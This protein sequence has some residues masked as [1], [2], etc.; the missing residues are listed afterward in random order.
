MADK[1]PQFSK[2]LETRI[3][4]VILLTTLVVSLL[5][6]SITRHTFQG[7]LEDDVRA[8]THSVNEY[9]QRVI[10]VESFALLNERDDAQLPEYGQ[11]QRVLNDI[12]DIANI[13]YLFSAKRNSQGTIVYVVD[14]L[15]L[16]S[17]DFRFI[18]DPVEEEILP[19]M[20]TCLGGRIVGSDDILRTSWG[21]I[22]FTCWPVRGDDGRVVGA[23]V[24]EFDAAGLAERDDTATWYS[25]VLSLAIGAA[26]VWLAR[27]LLQK[28]SE[29]FY[30][31]LAYLDFLTELGNRM[32]FEQDL[33]QL[34]KDMKP[35]DVVSI[36]TYDLNC[37]KAINDQMGHSAGD[38]YLRKMAGFITD[39]FPEPQQNYRLGGDEF[40]TVVVGQ[41]AQELEALLAERFNESLC[42][43]SLALYFSFSFGVATFDPAVDSNL[44]D[45][46]HRADNSM[47]AFKAQC[48]LREKSP[49]GDGDMP[50][51]V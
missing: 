18:N 40:A 48:K 32:A 10:Q 25:V 6:L 26:F 28:V 49:S 12:R 39:I 44:H 7:V 42:T 38:T 13:R 21:P 17:E 41:N 1:E 37:L 35:E 47:Y 45:V 20:N 51:A 33:Q 27:L 8:R 31:K 30:K 11:Q 9:A 34:Q 4:L 5:V 23:V 16:G 22:L 50:R 3:F 24:M 19:Q 2:R 36:V 46:L 15:P 43:S 29:P 14:G